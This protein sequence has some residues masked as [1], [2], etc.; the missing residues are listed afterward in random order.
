MMAD[1]QIAL[2]ALRAIGWSLWDPIGLGAGDGPGQGVPADEYDEYLLHVAG[3]IRQAVT[4]DSCIAYLVEIEAEHMALGLRPS[5]Q[6]RAAATVRA[7]R[8]L[9]GLIR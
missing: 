2:S 8:G 4:D 1:A 5:T 9:P 6:E 3:L 7:M